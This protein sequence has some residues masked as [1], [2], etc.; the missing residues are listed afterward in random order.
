MKYAAW[1]IPYTRPETPAGLLL[2][3]YSPLLAAVLASRGLTEPEAVR[4]FLA[5]KPLA[6]PFALTDMDKAAARLCLA[7]ERREHVAVYGDYDVDGITATCLLGGYLLEKGL[8]CE[9]YIPDRLEEGYGLNRAAVQALYDRGVS[10]IVTV[11]CGVTAEAEVAFAAGLPLD[12]VITDHHQCQARLPGALAVVDP[13]RPDDTSGLT[14]LA[15]VGVAFALVCALEGDTDAC[16]SRFCDLAA[17]GT[18]ADVM[19]LVGENRLILKAGLSKL[20]EAPRPGLAALVKEAGLTKDKLNAASVSY[21]LAPR[22]NAAGRLGRSELAVNLLM[23]EDP[24]EAASLAG[25][26]CALNRSRQQMETSI[27]EEA[28]AMLPAE[29]EGPVVLASEHWH[30][31]VVGIVASRLAESCHLPVVLICFEGEQGKG[32]CRSF[33]DFSMFDALLHC[34][35][36][37]E[38][39]G[40]HPLAAG[41]TIRRENLEAFRA[42]FTDYFYAHPSSGGQALDIDL[43]VDAPGLLRPDCVE[44]LQLLEPCGSG[45]PRPLLCLTDAVLDEVVPIGGGKHLRLVISKF[46]RRID[47]VYFSHTPE[48]LGL[49]PGARVDVAFFAQINEFRG[50]SGVQLQ[51]VDIRPADS[52]ALCR[53]VLRGD[54]LLPAVLAPYRPRRRDFA[55]LWRALDSAGGAVDAPAGEALSALHSAAPVTDALCLTVFA[56]LG[57]LTLDFDGE[58]LRAAVNAGAPRVQLE[59]SAILRQLTIDN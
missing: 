50:R 28:R 20:R 39:F 47:C 1:K 11:D 33:G 40:G 37:L 17:L 29:P 16:L 5:G 19:P 51:I 18:V 30:Q 24:G 12:M 7:L 10:L 36:L 3:G 53:A 9:L 22:I 55:R 15:G 58:T 34:A 14:Q 13:K 8:P 32:S 4:A 42:A 23:A 54:A 25:Q 52:R 46:G 48:D 31:G 35:P 26:L 49:A 56:E 27:W 43:L 6:D 38:G 45:N 44:S 57:L 21:S 2:E 41:F 59:D